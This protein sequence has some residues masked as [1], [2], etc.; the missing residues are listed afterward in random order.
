MADKCHIK[1][2]GLNVINNAA[3]I[4]IALAEKQNSDTDKITTALIGIYKICFFVFLC[5]CLNDKYFQKKKVKK[6]AKISKYNI[7]IL[8]KRK[9]NE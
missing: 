5:V 8:H 7:Y 2:S 3:Q 1:G 4:V 6:M 9:K